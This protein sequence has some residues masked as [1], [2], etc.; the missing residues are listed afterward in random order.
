MVR[1]QP[2]SSLYLTK[3]FGSVTGQRIFI[4]LWLVLCLNSQLNVDAQEPYWSPHWRAR[5][6]IVNVVCGNTGPDKIMLLGDSILESYFW[7]DLS[8]VQIVNAGMGGIGLNDLLP[9]AER[10]VSTCRPRVVVVMVGTNHLLG[11]RI[12]SLD[13]SIKFRR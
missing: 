4:I 2:T 10:L 3:R 5:E 12:T 8:G 6:G 13:E 11:N 7:N 9:I 1:H